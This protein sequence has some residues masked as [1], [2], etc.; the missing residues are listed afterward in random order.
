MVMSMAE[1]IGIMTVPHALISKNSSYAYITKRV[2]RIIKDTAVEMLAMEDFCQLDFRLTQDKYKGSYERCAKIIERYSNRKG[3]DLT[4]L[5]LRLIFS[6]AVGNSDMH[7]KNFSLVKTNNIYK[8]APFYD[9]VPVLMVVKQE[10]MALTVN[11]KEKNITKNDTASA[12][13]SKYITPVF[14]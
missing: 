3:L 2:D 5:F 1:T 13:P 10:E 12:S 6:F 11:G 7:L 8:I 9:L 4:E 14:A